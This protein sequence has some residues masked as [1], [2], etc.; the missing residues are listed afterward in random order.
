M[1]SVFEERLGQEVFVTF[2]FFLKSKMAQRQQTS[3]QPNISKTFSVKH[4]KKT[5]IAF[6]LTHV[7]PDI[8]AAIVR[9]LRRGSPPVYD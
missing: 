7:L 3:N 9:D 4:K 5:A 6:S 2:K 1:T 8:H